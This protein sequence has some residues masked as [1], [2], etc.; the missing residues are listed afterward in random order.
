MWYISENYQNNW[1]L[2]LKRCEEGTLPIL[3][4]SWHLEEETQ[5]LPGLWVGLRAK[6]QDL[7]QPEPGPP[8]RVE[9]PRDCPLE[10]WSL[11]LFLYVIQWHLH[12]PSVIFLRLDRMWPTVHLSVISFCDD[13]WTG[14]ASFCY[15][16]SYSCG[17]SAISPL[18][19]ELCFLYWNNS[20][21]VQHPYI[22]D[23]SPLANF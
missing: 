15:Q 19:Y 21:L 13:E 5:L 1:I 2:K 17:H 23:N 12:Y 22:P 6:S 20:L 10:Q 8:P 14:Q 18:R 9:L 3:L 16:A 4:I 7:T 11:K